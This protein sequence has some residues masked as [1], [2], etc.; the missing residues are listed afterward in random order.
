MVDYIDPPEPFELDLR[1]GYLDKHLTSPRV[2]SPRIVWNAHE[3]TMLRLLKHQLSESDEFTFSVAFVTAR[4]IAMLKQ[5]F[6]DFR[7]RGLI[8]TSDYLSFNAPDAFQEL[9]GLGDLGVETRIHNASAFHPKGYIF[10]RDD[11]VTSIFGSSNLTEKALV[12]N[13]EWNLQVSA[14]RGSNLAEQLDT[15][16]T[17]EVQRSEPLTQA[18]IDEYTVGYQRRKSFEVLARKLAAVDRQNT[19]TDT[20]HDSP[21][22]TV[23]PNSMQI[24]A[25]EAL[26]DLR[27]SGQTK[28]LIVSATGTGKTILAALDVRAVRPQTMLF[29]AH[30]EQIIDKA[31][32][33][34]QRVLNE[35]GHEFGKL[36]GTSKDRGT[37]YLFATVQTLSRP[38]ML[39]WFTP[40]AFDYIILDEAHRS[41]ARSFERVLEQFHP[42]FLLGMS[43][44]PERTDGYD[45]FKHFD[46]N[47][48]YEIRLK[49]ALDADILTPF[50][51]YGI[52]DVT[53]EDG[54]IV[55]DQTDV[56]N[57]VSSLRVEHIVKIIET[58]GQKA[59]QPRG[60]I[61]CSSKAE[62]HELSERLNSRKVHG[63]LLRTRA[64]TGED[65]VAT[66]ELAVAALERG[67]LNYLLSVDIFNEG[68][69]IPTINQVVMLRQTQSSI[70]FIQQLG[71]GLRKAP[72][73]E[74]VVVLDFIGNYQNNF[75]IP[76]AL[77][78]DES[79]NKESLRLN[80]S[81]A[82][83]AETL[84]GLS[85]VSFDRVALERVLRS[86]T[87]TKLNGAPLIR[88]AF[89]DLQAR[90][91]H[92]PRFTDF[93]RF[94]SVDPYEIISRYQNYEN[95]ISKMLRRPSCV[96]QTGLDFLT[97][98]SIEAF[99]SRRPHDVLVLDSLIRQG[100]AS[101]Q[102]LA[103]RVA[104]RVP[105]SVDD[106]DNVLRNLD[107]SFHT[108]PDRKKYKQKIL[109]RDA[110][111]NV[112]LNP[113]F[114]TLYTTDLAFRLDVDDLL[115]AGITVNLNRYA[116]GTPMVPGKQYTRKDACRLFGWK[117]NAM[118]TMFGYQANY[119]EAICPIFVNYD[120]AED[121]S[122]TT[123]YS[124]RFIDS[125]TML[126][127]TKNKRTL[128]SPLERA[129]ASNQVRAE[130]FVKRDHYDGPDYYYLGPANA[131]EARNTHMAN[132]IP[133]ATMHLNLDIPVSPSL[134]EYLSGTHAD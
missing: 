53:L 90:L 92:P 44:T 35:P 76:I 111:G 68:I 37:K 109:I 36:S 17:E 128:D 52:A 69:D 24:E 19:P 13:H 108:E 119:S 117:K 120:K 116:S 71:R 61:F 27:V 112:D 118:A 77:L 28:G 32:T 91:G 2:R 3:N 98:A 59:E 104:N 43:A 125:S 6:V 131:T 114:R 121:V 49:Q 18:W 94:E 15:L 63:E 75:M 84:P 103:R 14:N 16:V 89:L 78:G 47:V 39:K 12:S 30:R 106:I 70:V 81:R 96:S 83:E 123:A 57:L 5:A 33:E 1:F 41:G 51:Y 82:T 34:F 9:L 29:V 31:M 87:K 79:L 48:P 101:R 72:G 25:L 54:T 74:Y 113:S 45:I 60:L 97:Y 100:A 56:K 4:A 21:A 130:L 134:Y 50:H 115:E 46:Y 38:D 127:Y 65:S 110:N 105:T 93:L 80:L 86:I 55:N 99:S 126:W 22:A 66:R 124:D 20:S 73:K 102:L 95:F 26:H 62:A 122:A 40:D 129:I 88:R 11:H 132:K 64:L 67:E 23:T 8:V 85:S 107:L 58:Y 10:Q 133:V 7:G 42:K